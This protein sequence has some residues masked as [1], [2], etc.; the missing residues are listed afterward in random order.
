MTQCIFSQVRNYN[1]YVD[2]I[3]DPA[4]KYIK[5]LQ[6]WMTEKI[7]AALIGE[8]RH[9]YARTYRKLLPRA[10][11]HVYRNLRNNATHALDD[12]QA[13]SVLKTFLKNVRSKHALAS[14]GITKH[15]TKAQALAM[16]LSLENIANYLGASGTDGGPQAR[17]NNRTDKALAKQGREFATGST[18]INTAL[19]KEHLIQTDVAEEPASLASRMFSKIL[20]NGLREAEVSQ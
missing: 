12:A 14:I 19:H 5:S 1:R 3:A 15:L 20:D 16:L 10:K 4:E 7:D 8:V 11:R 13:H 17:N 18:L 6:G 9:E 2:K